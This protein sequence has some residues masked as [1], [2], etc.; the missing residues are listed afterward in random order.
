MQIPLQIAPIESCGPSGV[1]HACALWWTRGG[2]PEA[3]T[4]GA[5]RATDPGRGNLVVTPEVVLRV[6]G[7]PVTCV[8]REPGVSGFP[9]INVVLLD[10]WGPRASRPEARLSAA[11][12]LNQFR[13]TQVQ[14]GGQTVSMHGECEDMLDALVVVRA[15]GFESRRSPSGIALQSPQARCVSARAARCPVGSRM[16]C[17]SAPPV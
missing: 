1:P 14:T 15:V 9:H 4:K 6:P 7:H 10:S 17:L 16:L 13:S 3:T 11:C 2:R 8:M 12:P 5:R